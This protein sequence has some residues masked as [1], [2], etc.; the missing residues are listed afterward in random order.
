MA[1]LLTLETA[2]RTA[3]G[4]SNKAL[5]R[6]GQVPL[7]VF[8]HGIES[9]NLEADEIA[10]TKI[11]H[12]AGSSG[13]I[14]LQVG[15][16]AQNVLVRKVQRHPVNH[17]LIHVDLYQVQM[18]Q[19]TRVR[20]PLVFVGDAPA[21]KMLDGMVQHHLDALNVEALPG[22]LPHNIEVDLSGLTELDQSL[23][24]RDIRI[25]DKL[26]VL[27]EPDELVVK[28]QAT[29]VSAEEAPTPA[30]GEAPA[31][32]STEAQGGASES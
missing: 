22:D 11:L 32:P 14:K 27:E 10:L 29:R 9:Q 24:V 23:F 6:S 16:K 8:G 7:H 4:K 5:R 25:S 19:K 26:R 12:K 28:V 21:V 13:L 31:A 20:L 1:D 3:T 30:E 17:R 2:A 18:D 15:G